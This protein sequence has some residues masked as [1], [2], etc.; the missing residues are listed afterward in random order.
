MHLK[1]LS[2]RFLF[3]MSKDGF[4]KRKLGCGSFCVYSEHEEE[5]PFS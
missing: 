2:K 4:K 5:G 3:R 1:P